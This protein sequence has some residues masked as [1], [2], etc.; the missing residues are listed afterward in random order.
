MVDMKEYSNKEKLVT[1]TEQGDFG[2]GLGEVTKEEELNM[3]QQ[4]LKNMTERSSKDQLR[5]S[6]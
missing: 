1:I 6:K 5:N 2:L 4:K 3:L